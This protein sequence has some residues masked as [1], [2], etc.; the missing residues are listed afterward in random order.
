MGLLLSLGI[1][2]HFSCVSL[3]LKLLCKII[4]ELTFEKFCQRLLRVV[5]LLMTP[6]S[7]HMYVFTHDLE[8]IYTY[9]YIST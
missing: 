4:V 1:M 7:V 2:H 8:Y 6:V 9:K 3:L 5:L